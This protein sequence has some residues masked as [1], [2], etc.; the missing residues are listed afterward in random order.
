M[1]RSPIRR[2]IL[3]LTSFAFIGLASLPWLYPNR[4]GEAKNLK[5]A[6]VESTSLATQ[7]TVIGRDCLQCHRLVVQTFALNSHGKSAKF[8]KDNRAADC[9]ACH[10]NSEK[11]AETSSRTKMGEPA[12]SP[13]NPTAAQ[14]NESCLMC[15]R[16]DR[17]HFQ[18][19]GGQHDRPDMSCLSCHSVHHAKLVQ[20]LSASFAAA[21]E[22]EVAE[23]IST[24]LPEHSMSR[25]TIEETCLGCH[26]EQR[27]ALFQRSTHLFRTELRNM[28]VGCTSCHN[29]H[30]GQAG[31]MLREFTVNNV[32]YT[33]HAEKRGPF[34]WDHPPV[35]EN[36]LN[37]HSPHGSNNPKL[38]TARAHLVCQQ[39]HI[40]MLPRHSTTAGQAL[41]IW[42]INRGCMNCH[43]QVHG[44]NHPGGRTLTR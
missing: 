22:S 6:E 16:R 42:S 20:T 43:A 18:W 28:K 32:C 26:A 41:D 27:K 25:S 31:R 36:C 15:H 29:P 37:C 11:H 3:L 12:D 1:D 39:C 34:L 44:S 13:A 7:E 2:V 4:R 21:P 17:T 38:L 14:T 10:R 40:H 23:L 8:L 5:T 30:G 9:Q 33:C 24:R 35:R 19:T